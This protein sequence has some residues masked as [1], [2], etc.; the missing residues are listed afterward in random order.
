ME[1]AEHRRQLKED[2]KLLDH[3]LN[4][5]LPNLEHLKALLRI[6][7]SAVEKARQCHQV[8]P[9]ISAL[10]PKVDATLHRM[11]DIPT[12]C[13]KGCSHCCHIWVS[14]SA[15]EILHIANIVRKR[16]ERAIA[17]VQ[18]AFNATKTFNFDE[19][20]NHPHPCP[21]LERDVC[22]IYS[23]RPKACRLA[24]SADAGICARSYHNTTD[25]DIPTPMMYLVARSGYAV[26]YAVA[27]KN[28]GLSHRAYELN[29]GLARALQHSNAETA[30]LSGEDVFSGVQQDPEDATTHANALL[31]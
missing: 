13:G 22:S 11:R 31:G 9:I 12:S 7:Q 25:E 10:Y 23:D 6:L 20:S 1:R 2:Q 18:E 3:G 28:A 29:A 16:G 21:L 30:W 26:P 19:R 14:A 5:E 27:L 24:A 15:P 4:P 17:K 8:E